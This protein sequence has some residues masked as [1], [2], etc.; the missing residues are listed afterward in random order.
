[1]IFFVVINKPEQAVSI[2][3]QSL[4]SRNYSSFTDLVRGNINLE[5]EI[6]DVS[7][8]N[9]LLVEGSPLNDEIATTKKKPTRGVNFSAEEDKLLV[10]AWLNTSVDPVY[11][12][13]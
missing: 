8:N 9:P 5:D 13:E 1:M 7:E 12:N 4:D 3:I 11:G 10:A 6:F 2:S